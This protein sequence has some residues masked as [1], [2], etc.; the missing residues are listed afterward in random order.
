MTDAAPTESDPTWRPDTAEAVRDVVAW[1]VAEETPIEIVGQGSKR[2]I[3]RPMQTA[4]TL[5]LSHLTGIT[6]YEPDELVL[7]ARAG[8]PMAE[9]E[10][11]LDEAGQMLAFE[12][13]DYAALLGL[14]PGH[15]TIG[16]A[17]MA[18]LSGPRRLTAGAAR[19]QV[20]GIHAVSGRGEAFKSGGRVMKNVTGY[21][22]SR[23]LAGSW[24]TLAVL[25]DVTLKVL[26]RPET[27]A[28]VLVLGLEDHAAVRAMA[29]AVGSSTEVSGA[30]HLPHR[31]AMGV[32]CVKR[33]G[34]AVTALRLEG[35]GPSVAYR[36]DK[37]AAMMAPHGA[38]ETL[39]AQASRTFWRVVRDAEP[40]ARRGSA[41]DDEI[42]RRQVWRCSTA[43]TAGPEL[44]RLMEGFA[45][46]EAFYDWAGG[47]VWLSL[48][49]HDDAMAARVRETIAEVGGH[50]TLIRAD[51]PVRNAVPVFQPQAPGLAALA[52]RMKAQFDPKGV[53]NPGRM[54]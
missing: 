28:T 6:L 18:N 43:P 49:P 9:I 12:P 22:L 17:V 1:A 8:T 38:V 44:V 48:P 36:R 13:M 4:A 29:E 14:E 33:F 15:G 37:L 26:P 30:A 35:F 24:G 42:D 54:G 40:F 52:Q 31:C 20:L 32:A 51:A 47:L 27:L 23:G 11:A 5:D 25:T 2:L 7:S 39:D 34:R 21:D 10:E 46:V 19:D 3:G 41:G 16:G 45:D 53:L 50:A